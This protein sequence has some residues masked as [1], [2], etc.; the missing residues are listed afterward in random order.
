MTGLRFNELMSKLHFW[1]MFIAFNST[2]GPIFAL[3]LMGMPRRVATYPSHLPIC[4]R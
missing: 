1:T 2:F 3:G 4:R